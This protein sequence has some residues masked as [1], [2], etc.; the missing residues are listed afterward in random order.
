[1][2]RRGLFLAGLLTACTVDIPPIGDSNFR[3]EADGCPE[4]L[5]CRGGWCEPPDRTVFCSST[6][7]IDP[8]TVADDAS[9]QRWRDLCETSDPGAVVVGDDLVTLQSSNECRSPQ[10][11]TAWGF[12]LRGSA[13][14][15]RATVGPAFLYVHGA[16]PKDGFSIQRQGAVVK[17]I[18]RIDDVL[19]ERVA[20]S[21]AGPFWRISE[22]DDMV[23]FGVSGDGLDWDEGWSG[24]A[25]DFLRYVTVGFGVQ[26]DAAEA[27]FQDL[28][29]GVPPSAWCP[30]AELQDDLRSTEVDPVWVLDSLGDCMVTQGAGEV[31]FA[32]GV[33]TNRCRYKSATRY[34]LGTVEV[35]VTRLAPV[36]GNQ[37]VEL[38]A[39]DP[40]TEMQMTIGLI[41]DELRCSAG[42][43]GAPGS[44]FVSVPYDAAAHAHW[45]LRAAAGSLI[46]EH[47]P[48][49]ETWTALGPGAPFVTS[50]VGIVIG[51]EAPESGVSQPAAARFRRLVT[52]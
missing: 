3:C 41:A 51:I 15:V 35:A 28:N 19:V 7:S 9:S 46:C 25:P 39:I 1:M 23:D 5:V 20:L 26:G 4:G 21:E 42:S 34:D 49:G 2:T 6:R 36:E 32:P 18:E 30:I 27:T 50:G 43:I 38:A 13:V 16:D 22:S 52:R 47:S 17:F 10:L 48:D 33:D 8:W 29:A 11:E 40:V 31:R 45:R 44:P 37:H 14:T 12:D 24:P